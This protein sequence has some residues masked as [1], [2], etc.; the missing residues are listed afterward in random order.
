MRIP[1]LFSWFGNKVRQKSYSFVQSLNNL[2]INSGSDIT[3]EN[4]YTEGYK[5]SIYVYACTKK[6]VDAIGSVNWV[7]KDSKGNIIQN[8]EKYRSMIVTVDNI[9][10][11][12]IN[13][14]LT[15]HL[16]LAGNAY[17]LK[18]ED[19]KKIE[20]ILMPDGITTDIIKNSISKYNYAFD[21]YTIG[22]IDPERMVH[23]KNIDPKYPYK[24]MSV[25]Q[26]AFATVAADNKAAS[27]NRSVLD[28][29]GRIDG[30]VITNAVMSEEEFKRY[31]QQLNNEYSGSN[32]AG[33]I[34]ILEGEDT[35]YQSIGQTAK[36]L[37]F[38]ESRNINKQDICVA[39]GVPIQML[40]VNN[41]T[42][43]NM[44]SAKQNFWDD[45][46]MSHLD[47]LK[48]LYNSA[49][50]FPDNV[51]I[52]YD[53]TSTPSYE[54]SISS[55]IDNIVKL[56]GIGYPMGLAITEL[57][58]AITPV[59]VDFTTGESKSIEYKKRIIVARKKLLRD[60]ITRTKER[61]LTRYFVIEGKRV[62]EAY[63]KEF[64]LDSV[65]DWYYEQFKSS[66]ELLIKDIWVDT[67]NTVSEN[68]TEQLVKTRIKDI[69]NQTEII[70]FIDNVVASKVKGIMDTT[71]LDIKS[72]IL[73]GFADGLTNENI[74]KNLKGLF[75]ETYKNRSKT[76]ARTEVG[77]AAS[78]GDFKAAETTGVVK[79]KIWMTTGG[80]D[81]RD[82]HEAINGQRRKMN[83]PFSN[84]LM[85][86][87]DPNGKASEVINCNCILIYD[88]IY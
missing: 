63:R 64:N 84:G 52:D 29:G 3:F 47:S 59:D 45:T 83:E 41:T 80:F 28:N 53:L 6:I 33:K 24:G 38:I 50:I 62:S 8:D 71:I 86:P 7:F 5:K 74:A 23:Y 10:F 77:G 85:Y 56:V 2:L 72:V 14:I 65:G 67:A 79:E 18:T 11:K 61:L 43:N 88:T 26:S 78:Y 75:E 55:K 39:F 27:W 51:T 66:W 22:N 36:D 21:D 37:D 58:L 19:N 60:N 13:K 30:V 32:N 70:D 49:K 17:I 82:T 34:M 73:S 68:T 1:R 54:Q 46:I 4:A 81:V 87:L 31:K 25:L 57:G 35:K 9:S 69:S 16:L 15:L 48:D 42:Y 20:R 44:D 12:R 76:I 40:G